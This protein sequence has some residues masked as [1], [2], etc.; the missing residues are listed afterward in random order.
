MG[1]NCVLYV[2]ISSLKYFM[3]QII[4]SHRGVMCQPIRRA[5]LWLVVPWLI[6]VPSGLMGATGGPGGLH[7]VTGGQYVCLLLQRCSPL[8]GM[9]V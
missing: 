7:C 8:Q 5:S 4:M 6:P 2:F 1:M 3:A 9:S